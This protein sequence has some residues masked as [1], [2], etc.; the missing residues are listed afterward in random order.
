MTTR[1]LAAIVSADVAGYSRLMEADETGTLA[2]FKRHRE[3]LIEPKVRQF[4]GRV[5]G[6]A[7]DGLLIEFGS[8][9]DAVQCA[10]E[11]QQG[12]DE[13]N[14]GLE[15]SRRMELRVGVNLGD[16]IVDGTDI[17][18][19]GVNVAARLQQMAVP[20]G[21]CIAGTVKEHVTGK[22][23]Y[24]FEDAGEQQVKNIVRAVHVFRLWRERAG[25]PPT[26][27]VGSDD[28]PL[29]SKPSVAVLPF[30]NMS[31]DPEQEYF[32]D[33]ITE[34]II[35]EL[36][37]FRS[38]FVVARNS[39]FV[40]KGQ[41]VN[42][43]DVARD[44]GVAYVVEGSVRKSGKR[45]R[46]TAQL[47]DAATGNH[48]WA[49]RYDRDLEDIFEIQDEVTRAVVSTV[50]YNIENEGVTHK[51]SRPIGSITAY[52]LVLRAW[53][54]LQVFTRAESGQAIDL[55][56]QAIAM[57]PNYSRAYAV[58]AQ[59]CLWQY[60]FTF[61]DDPAAT[62][63]RG[64][65]LAERAVALDP[66]ESFNH[67]V[68]G[69]ARFY[70]RDFG[71]AKLHID[72][73]MDLNPNNSQLMAWQGYFR[74]MLGEHEAGIETIQ[75]AR[76]LNPYMSHAEWWALGIAYF[77]ARRYEEAIAAL[78]RVPSTVCEARANVAAC[79]AHM[80]RDAEA[81]ETMAEFFACAPRELGRF[82][83]DDKEAWRAYWRNS[84]P[85]RLEEDL[86]H[87]LDGLRKAGLPV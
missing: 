80:G 21:V 64:I 59:A 54:K 87:M 62:M 74:M 68:L 45:I 30:T 31:G 77:T 52:D 19:D 56:E 71:Q 17:H 12:M 82:P 76:R 27:A 53:A 67:F 84:Y 55:L 28:L 16:V 9:V 79:L 4:G 43:Q 14:A 11:V 57:D 66:V 41:A 25:A 20:G 18:G 6:A 46:I 42:V 78:T 3:E 85:Y 72:Q 73:G 24:L 40:F 26:P 36:S 34:D 33:G 15:P 29:P 65:E 47:V 51:R 1:R 5:V 61:T 35:T 37:R 48:V 86:E 10:A 44:L 83:G 75:R 38:L 8:V 13:R 81:R 7:G 39:S 22:L 23:P 60:E 58:L 63:R 2:A 70:N 50:A 69:Y 32:S 49:E